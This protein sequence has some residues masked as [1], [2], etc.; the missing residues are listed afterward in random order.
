MNDVV[1]TTSP[2]ISSNARAPE[3]G[4]INYSSIHNFSSDFLK[5]AQEQSNH[6][7]LSSPENH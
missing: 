7:V 3:I 4:H 5:A 2:P 6:A 1:C